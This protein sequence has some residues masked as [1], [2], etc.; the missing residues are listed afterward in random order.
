MSIESA[1][2]TAVSGLLRSNVL[3]AISSWLQSAKN[4]TVTVDELAVALSLPAATQ[5][6]ALPSLSGSVPSAAAS[7]GRARSSKTSDRPKCQ[8]ILTRGPNKSKPCSKACT[9]ERSEDYCKTHIDKAAEAGS[10]PVTAMT[11][12]S[13]PGSVPPPAQA[14]PQQENALRAARIPGSDLLIDLD[15]RFVLKQEANGAVIVHGIMEADDKTIRNL[16]QS[17]IDL[18][19]SKQLSVPMQAGSQQS[20]PA[21][22]PGQVVVPSVPGVPGVPVVGE[23]AAPVAPTVPTV[24]VPVVGVP[25]VPTVAP[26]VPTVGVPTVPTVATVAPTVPTVGVPVV[27]VPTVAPTVPTVGV[28]VVGVP[29]VDTVPVVGVPVVGV[30]TVG[31]P[32]AGLVPTVPTTEIPAQ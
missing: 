1:F 10:R 11:A 8:W 17:E 29:T 6:A 32:V 12:P 15:D 13:V 2:T 31:A 22:S 24:G 20:T 27:G 23:S 18:A 30:P 21:H 16:T 9:D 26:T 5:M 7:S 28:P 14:A 25:T 3:P 4:V 19:L